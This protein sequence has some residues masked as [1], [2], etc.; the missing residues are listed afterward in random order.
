MT[1]NQHRSCYSLV[2]LEVEGDQLV[3]QLKLRGQGA[4]HLQV[5][6]VPAGKQKTVGEQ[7]AWCVQYERSC[8]QQL[9]ALVTKQ[10]TKASVGWR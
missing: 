8:A 7:S 9:D 5:G 2:A 10:A 6:Q 1:H 4:L 3:G